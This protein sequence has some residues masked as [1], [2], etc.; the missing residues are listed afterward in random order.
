MS[1]VAAI[2]HRFLFYILPNLK[3]GIQREGQ[4]IHQPAITPPQNTNTIYYLMLI[5]DK[6]EVLKTPQTH[7][8]KLVAQK[9]Q[10]LWYNDLH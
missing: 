3:L 2:T 4:L 1:V 7:L 5:P 10:L 6:Q 8:L 9:S